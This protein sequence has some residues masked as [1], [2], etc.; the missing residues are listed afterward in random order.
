M[1]DIDSRSI[2]RILRNGVA[3]YLQLPEEAISRMA[4]AIAAVA[5]D[6]HAFRMPRKGTYSVLVWGNEMAR[7]VDGSMVSGDW[8]SP[9]NGD[10][11]LIGRDGYFKLHDDNVKFRDFRQPYDE[12][13]SPVQLL[14]KPGADY[15][16]VLNV[17]D[18]ES[19]VVLPIRGVEETDDFSLG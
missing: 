14:V 8:Q 16:D 1:A 17:G 9:L 7:F 18:K 11:Y 2:E 12:E 19:T 3:D 4:Y 10:L 6:R 5:E 13:I 15:I